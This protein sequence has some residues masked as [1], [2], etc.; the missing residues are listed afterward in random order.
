ML[1]QLRDGALQAP[2]ETT[3]FSDAI[4]EPPEIQRLRADIA[5]ERVKFKQALARLTM[6]NF[7]PSS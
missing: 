1:E 4:L 2:V 7:G 6:A 3:R 5:D